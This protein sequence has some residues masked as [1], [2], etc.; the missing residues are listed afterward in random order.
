MSAQAATGRR[1]PKLGVVARLLPCVIALSALGALR[2]KA[3]TI[4][5]GGAVAATSH[6]IFRGL[7]QTDGQPALQL[8]GHLGDSTGW[9]GGVWLSESRRQEGYASTE[10]DGYLAHHWTWKSLWTLR[11]GYIHYAYPQDTRLLEYSYDEL[12]SSITYSDRLS[13]NFAWSPN[14]TQYSA[15][16]PAENRRS[17]AYEAS[18][19]QPIWADFSLTASAGFYDLHDLFGQSYW[20]WSGGLEW[21][22]SRWAATLAYFGADRTARRLFPGR[23]ANGKSALALSWSF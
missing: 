23:A 15:H 8:D 14:A 7:S 5:F 12:A 21:R 9:L 16:G 22:Q 19:R 13:L 1:G 4:A 3:E 18:L 17:Y 6:Y 2:A 20:A 11:L 10:L